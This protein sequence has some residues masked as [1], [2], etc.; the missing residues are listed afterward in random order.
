MPYRLQSA[1]STVLRT[2]RIVR[3]HEGQAEF[4]SSSYDGAAKLLAFETDWFSDYAIVYRDTETTD[5][6]ESSGQTET[7]PGT[8]DDTNLCY[9]A[10]VNGEERTVNQWK[11]R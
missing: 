9:V 4:L 11:I 8:G 5:Q 10:K 7:A 3:N 6:T 1:G 2:F